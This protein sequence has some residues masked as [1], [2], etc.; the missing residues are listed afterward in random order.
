[1]IQLP[2]VLS[3]AAPILAVGNSPAE[4]INPDLLPRNR[5]SESSM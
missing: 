4:Q 3:V 1:M 2:E 5:S